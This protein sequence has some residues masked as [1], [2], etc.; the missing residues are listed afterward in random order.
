MDRTRKARKYFGISI[1]PPAFMLVATC[2]ATL[3]LSSYRAGFSGCESEISGRSGY[4]VASAAAYARYNGDL[5]L[6]PEPVIER[7]QAELLADLE[8][9]EHPYAYRNFEDFQE[10]AVDH[11]RMA[12]ASVGFGTSGDILDNGDR[13]VGTRHGLPLLDTEDPAEFVGPPEPANLYAAASTYMPEPAGI[14]GPPAPPQ[15]ASLRGRDASHPLPFNPLEVGPFAD[16]RRKPSQTEGFQLLLQDDSDL[17]TVPLYAELTHKIRSG[18]TISAVLDKA[19]LDPADVETWI[20]AARKAYN[21][22]KIYVG[23]RLSVIVDGPTQSLVKL[24]LDIDPRTQLVA[25]R[26]GDKVVARREEV[27]LERHLRVVSG[28]IRSSLYMEAISKG[29]PDKVISEVA[30][31]LGWDLNFARDVRPGANFRVVYEELSRP[32]ESKKFPGRVMAVEVDNQSKR[33]EGFYFA[34]AKTGVHGYFDRKGEGLGR[35]FL[36]YPV[37]FSRISSHFTTHR[38]HPVLKRSK[39]HYGVDF[40]AP[41]GTPVHAVADGKVLKAGWVG[42]NGRFVKLRHNSVYDTGYAHLSRIAS[43]VHAGGTVKKGQIIGYVGST[44]LATGPHLHF[45]MYRHG[46]YI[47]P[48]K[49]NLPRA[50][51]LTGADLAAHKRMVAAVEDAYARADEDPA[52]SIRVASLVDGR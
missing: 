40:A 29:V 5:S 14:V 39:P 4:A 25:E 33:Y 50:Q 20:T 15:L 51:S 23:Q 7:E 26:E 44:G 24:E 37:S 3:S 42:G 49:A 30:E 22:N 36:R 27:E 38:F 21:L 35:F 46:T 2:V 1:S 16:S 12:L 32:D 9:I 34:D 13:I 11:P 31:I 41:T 52:G 19:G 28:Q 47:D 43:G 45:A 17:H 18:E 8:P 6:L 48:L 10:A